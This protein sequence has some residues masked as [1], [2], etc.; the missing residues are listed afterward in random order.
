[1]GY[2]LRF[3]TLVSN[4]QPFDYQPPPKRNG[5]T[6]AP[7]STPCNRSK[8]PITR[9]DGQSTDTEDSLLHHPFLHVLWREAGIKTAP[10]SRKPF[11][12]FLLTAFLELKP[13]SH[14]PVTSI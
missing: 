2:L 13:Q 8:I 11:F 12:L 10:F 3:S 14:E 9:N 5:R 6:P 1:M 4:E 7:R